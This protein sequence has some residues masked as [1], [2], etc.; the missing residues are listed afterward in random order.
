MGNNDRRLRDI[1]ILN[2][3]RII[4]NL[5]MLITGEMYLSHRKSVEGFDKVT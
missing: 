1:A 4:F 3:Q 5:S 2:Y